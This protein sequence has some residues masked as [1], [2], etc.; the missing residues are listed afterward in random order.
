MID[1]EGFL[2]DF[3]AR[4]IALEAWS[5][6]SHVRMAYLYLRRHPFDEAVK[7]VRA[8]IQ[9]FNAHHRIPD[10]LER[11]YHETLTIAWLRV[12]AATIASQGPGENSEDFCNRQPHLLQRTLLRLFYSRGR[13]MTW[14]AKRAFVEPD[15]LPLPAAI[16][17][18]STAG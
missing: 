3:E 1:D 10:E 12:I 13:M 7:K 4:R 18:P 15:L 6:R 5:H 11:G 14:E 16:D 8:G 2:C 9:A 17:P